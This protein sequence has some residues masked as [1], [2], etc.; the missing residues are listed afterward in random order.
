MLMFCY[1]VVMRKRDKVAARSESNVDEPKG[2]AVVSIKTSYVRNLKQLLRPSKIPLPGII[3]VVLVVVIGLVFYNWYQSRGDNTC[4][5]GK[6][7]VVLK[8]AVA[9]FDTNDTVPEQQ[10]VSKVQGFRNYQK[11][12]SCMYIVTVSAVLN[13]QLPQAQSSLNQFNKAYSNKGV[14]PILLQYESVDNLRM[15]VT[16]LQKIIRNA[17]GHRILMKPVTVQ[18]LNQIK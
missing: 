4:T 1:P 5:S 2:A 12:P 14:S 7:A 9:A 16:T 13:E 3:V 11:D 10:V 18:Q 15:S 8:E 6:N 17:N